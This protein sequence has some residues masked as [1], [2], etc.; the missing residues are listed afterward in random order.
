MASPFRT[1]LLLALLQAPAFCSA[2]AVADVPML[3]EAALELELEFTAAFDVLMAGKLQDGLPMMAATLKRSQR[4]L[5][6]SAPHTLKAHDYYAATLMRMGRLAEAKAEFELILV[7]HQAA[8][9]QDS[10]GALSSLNNLANAVAGLES[11]QAALPLFKQALAQR[12]RTVGE[13]DLDS[14][15]VLG[16]YAW[17]LGESGQLH[18]SLALVERAL[19]LRIQLQGERHSWTLTAMNNLGHTLAQLGRYADALAV[20]EKVLKIRMADAGERHPSTLVSMSNTALM[21]RKLGRSEEARVL[22]QGAVDLQTQTLGATHFSTM[23]SRRGLASDLIAL[24]RPQ[25]AEA[26]LRRLLA[27]SLALYGPKHKHAQ[28]TR[29]ELALALERSHQLAAALAELDL[30]LAIYLETVGPAHFDSIEVGLRRARL[31]RLLGRPAEATAALIGLHA[32]ALQ[33]YGAGFPLSLTAAT[34]LAANL[35]ALGR[36]AEAEPLLAGVVTAAEALRAEMP[37]GEDE[38]RRQQHR[39]FA[40]AYRLYAR[41]LAG[42]GSLDAAFAMLER[43]KARSLL[44][45]MA[46]RNTALAAGVPAEQWADLQIAR[47]ASH[48]LTAKLSEA[49]SPAERQAWLERLSAAK[50]EMA[51]RH[52]QLL[53]QYPHYRR[54]VSLAPA[55]RQDAKLL[56]AGALLVSYSLEADADRLSAMTLD[57]R[58]RLRW[59]DL[60]RLE[61]LADRV[62]SLRLWSTQQG[63]QRRRLVGDSGQAVEIVRWQQPGHQ[64]PNWRAVSAQAPA[65]EGGQT[66]PAGCRPL[67]SQIVWQ[68]ADYEQLSRTLSAQLLTPLRAELQGHR[69][70]LLSPDKALGLLPFDVLPWRGQPLVKAVALS[71]LASL[72]VLHTDAAQPPAA[73]PQGLALLAMANPEFADTGDNRWQALPA[74][75]PARSRAGRRAVQASRRPGAAADRAAGQRGAPAVGLP[76]GRVGPRP[77][78]VDRKPRLVRC[79]APAGLQ[80]DSARGRLGHHPAGGR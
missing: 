60:G 42:L 45:Q 59:H 47:E 16:D 33:Q 24:G 49:K 51:D 74:G 46:E 4:E 75:Q 77:P 29:V 10:R 20:H 53:A 50:A 8:G 78:C 3:A 14:C 26:E 19:A 5:G 64:L 1:A 12:A 11:A 48:V 13:D 61:G 63:S 43:S 18:P 15:T 80:A 28:Y 62:E 70:W 69:R 56:P 2:A 41:V 76:L 37:A 52:L 35:A 65:C 17:A 27:D 68:Q 21:L 38:A 54:V 36:L 34:E 66:R 67:E 6:E 55:R 22:H 30:A 7:R 40:D 73:T 57:A 72:S 44:E 71:Q 23:T 39:G 31:L 25:Q 79:R 58:G 9:S 32:A